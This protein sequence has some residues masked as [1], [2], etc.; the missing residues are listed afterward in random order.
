MDIVGIDWS[1]N[2]HT[3]YSIEQDKVFK[4]K[5]GIAGYEKL[6]K[7]VSKDA[8]FVIEES[9]N[10]LG[11]FLLSRGKEVY[12]LPPKRS[13]EARG[14]HSNGVKTDSTDAR[15]IALTYKEH[16]E[17]CIKATHDELG[18]LFRELLRHYRYYTDMSSRL[19]NKLQNELHNYFPEYA[20]VMGNSWTDCD[21]RIFLLT[22]CPDV[23]ELRKTSDK[24]INRHFKANHL[25][26]TSS[27]KRKVKELREKAIDWGMSK[28]TRDMIA[29]VATQLLEAKREKKKITKEMEKELRKSKY[30]II[31]TLPGVGVATGMALVTAFLTHEFKN[32]RDFQKYCGTM[33]IVSQSGNF[34]MCRMRKNCDKK[35][36]GILHMMAINA[37]K[38]GAWMKGYYDK[39][40]NKEGKKPSLALRALANILVK[41][42]FA[43]LRNLKA[44]DEEL[45]LSSRGNKSP[46]LNYT[47]RNSIPGTKKMK[48]EKLSL[49]VSVAQTNCHL[50][51]VSGSLSP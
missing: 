43:M 2:F 47:T 24:E 8:V 37:K 4:I 20:R 30:N 34:R 6:L 22:I 46:R 1:W 51:T 13:K 26:Y 35:L 29:N 16:P 5:D 36:R 27:L 39:K 50:G 28:Y 19:K 3:C 10:R 18:M 7:T 41:I 11:D 33:P 31:L 17:Y 15:C 25:R 44:Y 9:F 32:Y 12:L 38:C 45:F 14:Y 21:G 23:T 42:A 48:K 40:T 49:P